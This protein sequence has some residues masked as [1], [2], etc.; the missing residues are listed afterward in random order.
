[1]GYRLSSPFMVS[2]SPNF[3]DSLLDEYLGRERVLRI[4]YGILS[5]AKS[6][7]PGG[8]YPSDV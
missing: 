5:M 2:I 3:V 1:M 6:V 4:N 7:T 8:S